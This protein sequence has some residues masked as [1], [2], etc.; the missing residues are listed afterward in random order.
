[1]K[2]FGLLMAVVGAICIAGLIVML[3]C[4]SWSFSINCNQYL[5]RAGDANT[6]ELA[7][8]NIDTAL[9]YIEFYGLT[10]GNTGI[11]LTQ[12]ENDLGFWYV[13]LKACQSELAK[14]KS[15]TPQLER[16]NLLM[17]LRETLLDHND[18]GVSVTCPDGISLYPYNIPVFWIL[19]A[20]SVF[21]II[22]ICMAV[23]SDEF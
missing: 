11:F 10:N 22:G 20:V 2:A 9:K 14:V 6:I 8:Q 15:E 19:V 13:N 18:K 1:M 16:S 23:F 5:K 21:L 3:I 4:F 12:P 7:A 17:K